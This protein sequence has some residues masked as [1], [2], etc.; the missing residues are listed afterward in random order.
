MK[1]EPIVM[2]LVTCGCEG[3]DALVAALQAVPENV[4]RIIAHERSNPKW[5]SEAAYRAE[6]GGGIG[7]PFIGD[8]STFVKSEGHQFD[9]LM[10]MYRAD[11]K[12]VVQDAIEEASLQDFPYGCRCIELTPADRLGEMWGIQ[13][14][15]E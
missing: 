10:I 5:C 2:G 3:A 11:R 1:D 12:H 9:M 6:V 14:E 8:R 7:V 13:E 15:D 4:G